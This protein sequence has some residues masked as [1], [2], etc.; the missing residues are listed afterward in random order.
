MLQHWDSAGAEFL[1]FGESLM[2]LKV[3][4]EKNGIR[5]ENSGSLHTVSITEKELAACHQRP[6]FYSVVE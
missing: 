3:I 2:C 4:G 5:T 6:F 1:R